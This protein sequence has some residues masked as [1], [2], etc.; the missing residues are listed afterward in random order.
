MCRIA[1]NH[2]EIVFIYPISVNLAVIE[3]GNP[4]AVP[5]LPQIKEM[6]SA[7]NTLPLQGRQTKYTTKNA[8]RKG[9]IVG[10]RLR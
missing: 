5:E 2:C 7:A 1:A 4:G 10:L 6:Q 8:V 3:R 9:C